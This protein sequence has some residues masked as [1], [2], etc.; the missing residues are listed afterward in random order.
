MP[1]LC[2]YELLEDDYG[3]YARGNIAYINAVPKK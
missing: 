3:K 1:A 2:P